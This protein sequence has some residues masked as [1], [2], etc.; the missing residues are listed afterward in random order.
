MWDENHTQISYEE[1]ERIG[2]IGCAPL[3]AKCHVRYS[4]VCILKDIGLAAWAVFEDKTSGLLI[5]NA[6]KKSSGTR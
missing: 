5:Q 3:E 1:N 2:I 4:S 6:T